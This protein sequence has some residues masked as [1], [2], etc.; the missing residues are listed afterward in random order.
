MVEFTCKCRTDKFQEM[1]FRWKCVKTP[2]GSEMRSGKLGFQKWHLW[3]QLDGERERERERERD[4]LAEPLSPGATGGGGA[5]GGGLHGSSLPNSVWNL[6]SQ[7]C[8]L[9]EFHF[10][11][12]RVRHYLLDPWRSSQS[13]PWQAFYPTPA[14]Q[15]NEAAPCR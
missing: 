5:W 15:G 6:N 3:S 12:N 1:A 11:K 2:L 14:A 13:W 7:Q 10:W 4:S 8:R 9:Q